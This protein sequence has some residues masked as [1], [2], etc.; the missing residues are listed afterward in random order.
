MNLGNYYHSPQIVDNNTLA[1]RINVYE[2]TSW[3]ERFSSKPKLRTY[4]I[5]K[6]NLATEICFRCNIKERSILG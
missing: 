4:N 3:K 2:E 1:Q 6:E 5:L